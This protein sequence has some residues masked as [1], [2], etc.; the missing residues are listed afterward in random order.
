[1]V[2]ISMLETPQI[3][4]FLK[5]YFEKISLVYHGFFIL[6]LSWLIFLRKKTTKI[7]ENF[8]R[9]LGTYVMCYGFVI[10]YFGPRLMNYKL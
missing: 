4:K 5:T 7:D 1:M 8:V 10:F 2:V 9:F 6:F 3:H